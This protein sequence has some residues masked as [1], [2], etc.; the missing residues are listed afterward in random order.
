MIEHALAGANVADA[1]EQFLEIVVTQRASGFDPLVIEREA[2]DQKF[3]QSG[4]SPLAKRCSPCR[5]DAV[6]DGENGV[7]VVVVDEPG[8]L[9][10]SLGL[11]Y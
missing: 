3:A 9:P 10:F 7:E 6:P 11:N 4:R 1:G 2:F 5:P 8:N